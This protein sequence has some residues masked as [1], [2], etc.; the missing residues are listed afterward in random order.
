MSHRKAKLQMKQIIAFVAGHSGGHIIPCITQAKKELAEKAETDVLFFSTN[1]ELDKKIFSNYNFIKYKMFLPNLSLSKK[2][3]FIWN[4]KSV[5]IQSLIT[6]IKYRPIKIVSMG[7]LVSV[8]VCLAAKLLNI[9]IV[10]WE[11][12]VEPGKA[13]KFISKLTPNINICFEE[14]RKYFKNKTCNLVAY[15]VRFDESLKKTNQKD[16][17]EK[18]GFNISKKTLFIIGGSQ[19]STFINNLV[20]D[21]IIQNPTIKE[22]IQVIHQTGADKFDWKNF[23]QSAQINAITFDFYNKVEEYYMAADIIIC[24]SGAGTLAEVLFFEKRCI[25]V[26]LKTNTTSHQILNADALMRQY[27]HLFYVIIQNDI[28]QNKNLFFDYILTLIS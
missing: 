26:P 13:V 8:P 4:F 24:R 9:P 15:P 25:T 6:L 11:L 1:S 21:F 16:I 7:G 19:G 2:L 28:V 27:P 3:N 17:L 14:T 23:Y 10:L 18:I 5:F 12:N 20:K 22:K